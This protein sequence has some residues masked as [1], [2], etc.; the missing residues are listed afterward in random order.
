MTRHH[1]TTDEAPVSYR[2][3]PRCSWCRVRPAQ[4]ATFQWCSRRC[5]CEQIE[6]WRLAAL[7]RELDEAARAGNARGGQR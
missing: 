3:S 7:S 6:D 5:R 4:S 1:A 2:G